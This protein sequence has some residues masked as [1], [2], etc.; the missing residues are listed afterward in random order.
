[1]QLFLLTLNV[2]PGK[3]LSCFK[4][5]FQFFLPN[6]ITTN[7]NLPTHVKVPIN[8]RKPCTDIYLKEEMTLLEIL[9]QDVQH[10]HHLR[11]DK[12]PVASLFQSAQQLVQQK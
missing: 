5:G 10:T 3:T 12:D 11:E 1:M 6:L 2:F 7:N 8:E 9:C 4:Y